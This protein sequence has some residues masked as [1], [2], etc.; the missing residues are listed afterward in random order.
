MRLCLLNVPRLELPGKES[1]ILERRDA[2]LLAW[3]A[4]EGPTPRQRVAQLVWPESSTPRA[5]DNN[6]RQRLFRLHKKLGRDVVVVDTTLRL[7]DEITHDLAAVEQ[8]L[9]ADPASCT[10]DV[11]GAFDYDEWEQLAV[12]VHAMRARWR[13]ARSFALAQ[14]AQR[15]ESEGRVAEALRHAERLVADEPALESAHRRVMQLHKQRGDHAAAVAAYNRL[16][17]ALTR[18]VDAT[19]EAQTRAL[20][21]E[22]EVSAGSPPQRRVGQRLTV[23]RPPRLV[24][25]DLEWAAIES[26]LAAKNN[27]LVSG[28][29]GI[30]KTR[31]L[32]DFASHHGRALLVGARAGDITDPYALIARLLRCVCATCEVEFAPWVHAELARLLPELGQPAAGRLDRLRLR[33]AISHALAAASAAGTRLIVLDDLHYGDPTSMELLLSLLNTDELAVCW[34]IGARTDASFADVLKWH[35]IDEVRPLR[36]LELHKLGVREIEELLQSLALAGVDVQALAPALV[37]HT[38]GNPLFVLETLRALESHGFETSRLE[39]SELRLLANVS[40][41]IGARVRQLSPQG[42]ALAQIAALAAEDF[43]A[44]LATHVLHC[45]AVDL[46]R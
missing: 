19:P 17:A 37:R 31:L 2:A 33:F 43:S 41:L 45:R 27:V 46:V 39:S 10:G 20:L 3:F 22:I 29:A 40:E 25:R 34:L 42:L 13:A 12:W 14:I 23:L 26:A 44:E 28:E 30:G 5:A 15:L 1:H 18:E 38:G 6:L 21:R 36:T 35:A 32:A 16:C 11:L 8:D 24:G 7:V 9:L 4:L